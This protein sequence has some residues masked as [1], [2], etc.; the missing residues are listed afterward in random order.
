MKTYYHNVITEEY[1]AL[2][3]PSFE[4]GMA[5]KSSWLAWNIIR[6]LR[7]GNY[8]LLRIWDGITINKALS[9]AGVETLLVTSDC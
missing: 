5:S 2:C 1:F 7:S 6:L 4:T 3:V 8:T 9:N